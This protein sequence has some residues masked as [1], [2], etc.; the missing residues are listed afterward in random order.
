MGQRLIIQIKENGRIESNCYYHWSGFTQQALPLIKA[1]LTEVI[2]LLD[3]NN[4]KQDKINRYAPY[5]KGD[6]V[7]TFDEDGTPTDPIDFD[8]TDLMNDDR[9]QIDINAF[10][11][12]WFH[13]F[14]HKAT[15][16][17][18]PKC[19]SKSPWGDLLP[20]SP[21]ADNVKGIIN[22]TAKDIV[23]AIY[24]GEQFADISINSI[25]T[26]PHVDLTS[27]FRA[28]DPKDHTYINIEPASTKAPHF[29]KQIELSR[30][31]L[32]QLDHII[33]I[34]TEAINKQGGVINYQDHLIIPIY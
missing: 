19:Q 6:R 33:D 23:E 15:G 3:P 13:I 17:A 20:Y 34:T 16:A 1:T 26:E 9:I 14:A 24:F 18:I 8:L 7:L 25:D 28:F 5:F 11:Q 29:D 32:P 12:S 27:L 22:L 10:C 4:T 21:E 30:V 2:Y 31:T